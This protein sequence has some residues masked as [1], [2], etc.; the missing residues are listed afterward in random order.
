M[1]LTSASTD[2]QVA[3]AYDD[4][5]DY[6]EAGDVAKA[7][8]FAQACRLLIRR[9]PTLVGSIGAQIA[10]APQLIQTQLKECQDWLD[11]NDTARTAGSFASFDFRAGRE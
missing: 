6:R 11:R 9:T 7:R 3:A 10:Q 8:L 2:D 4:N 1:S 5:A